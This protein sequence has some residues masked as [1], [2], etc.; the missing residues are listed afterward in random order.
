MDW[1]ELNWI[2]LDWIGLGVGLEWIELGW[3]EL[4]WIKLDWIGLEWIGLNWIELNWI[5]LNWISDW[6]Q[7]DCPGVPEE[8]FRDGNNDKPA[9]EWVSHWGQTFL[10]F[11]LHCF[12]PFHFTLPSVSILS[13]LHSFSFFLLPPLSSCCTF[14]NERR[15]LKMKDDLWKWKTTFE[16]ERWPLKTKDDLK[17]REKIQLWRSCLCSHREPAVSGGAS[18]REPFLWGQRFRYQQARSAKY[19]W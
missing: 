4:N 5:E 2:E 18:R 15:P 6:R 3:I 1:I 14:K 17:K 9:A 13:L 19:N 16:N 8:R 12:Y 11:I 7:E 10:H